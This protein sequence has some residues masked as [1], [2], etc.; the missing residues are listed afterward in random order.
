VQQYVE[1]M[2]SFARKVPVDVIGRLLRIP[3]AWPIRAV[4][5]YYGDINYYNVRKRWFSA[6]ISCQLALGSWNRSVTFWIFP[7]TK[8]G[9]WYKIASSFA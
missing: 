7:R 5:W 6:A 4:V 9:N 2:V 8:P 1:M 3:T